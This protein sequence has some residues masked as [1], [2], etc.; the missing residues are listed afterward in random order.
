MKGK[1][2]A[3]LSQHRLFETLK[4]VSRV[5]GRP[6]HT[7]FGPPTSACALGGKKPAL[8]SS[9][10]TRGQNGAQ[11]W[12]RL[13]GYLPNDRVKEWMNDPIGGPPKLEEQYPGEAP[14]SRTS[15]LLRVPFVQLAVRYNLHKNWAGCH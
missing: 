4:G 10:V 14:C 15:V 8:G 5:D 6:W 9:Y 3:L 12:D 11:P 1:P 7:E 2:S 13:H